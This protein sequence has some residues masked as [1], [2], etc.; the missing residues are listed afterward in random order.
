MRLPLLASLCVLAAGCVHT[1]IQ[2]VDPVVRPARSAESV[3]LLLEQPESPYT[4]VAVIEAKGETLFDSFDDLRRRIL[5]EAAELGGDAVI[6]GPELTDTD[7]IFTGL[8]MIRS[9]TRM[10][11]GQVIVYEGGP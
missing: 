7:F 1:S 6:V 11:S 8:T 2:R 5:T 4:V 3:T 9:D 10:L